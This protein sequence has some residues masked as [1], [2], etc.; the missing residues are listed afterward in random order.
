MYS[1]PCIH[2]GE[3]SKRCQQSDCKP[4]SITKHGNVDV[5]ETSTAESE[6]TNMRLE[7]LTTDKIKTAIF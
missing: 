3:A 4:G 1:V 5:P 2:K 7:V 6:V